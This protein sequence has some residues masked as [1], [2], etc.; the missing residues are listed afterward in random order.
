VRKQIFSQ[1]QGQTRPEINGKIIKQIA[2]P[3]P[4]LAE[5]RRIVTEVEH[6]ISHCDT[7][8]E[9]ITE[10]LQKAESLRQSIL[11]KAFEGKLLNE[12]ELEEARNAPDWEPAEK[13]LERICQ[14][15]QIKENNNKPTRRKTH[16]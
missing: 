12:K 13:L 1:V 2:V 15:K 9:T 8:E 7:M 4:H 14:E 16:G 5:Q 3:V 10:S 11:K 6:R